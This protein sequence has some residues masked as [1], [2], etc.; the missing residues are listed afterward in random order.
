M[1]H[2]PHA[3]AYKEFLSLPPST[4]VPI[5]LPLWPQDEILD[6]RQVVFTG[7]SEKEVCLPHMVLKAESL[8][9]WPSL[10]FPGI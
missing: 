4:V 7:M 10:M 5:I 3:K 1:A 2:S 9:P 8:L 6:L